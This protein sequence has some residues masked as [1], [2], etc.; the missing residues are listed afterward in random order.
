[1][2]GGGA[3]IIYSLKAGMRHTMGSYKD[4]THSTTNVEPQTPSLRLARM[5]SLAAPPA[6]SSL[7]GAYGVALGPKEVHTPRYPPLAKGRQW[8][9]LQFFIK[10]LVTGYGFTDT[11][12]LGTGLKAS[13]LEETH[14]IAL[15]LLNGC[16]L[17]RSKPQQIHNHTALPRPSIA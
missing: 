9:Q 13:L 2:P 10:G 1:M 17:L 4:Q 3:H 15:P 11:H 16:L 14:S 7:V 6:T 5:S 8:N 12:T